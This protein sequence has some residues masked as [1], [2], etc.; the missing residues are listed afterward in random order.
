[1]KGYASQF[2]APTGAA[3]EEQI[4]EAAD[5]F[6]EKVFPNNTDRK[7]IEQRDLSRSKIVVGFR[8]GAKWMAAF[9]ASQQGE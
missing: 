3:S 7:F 9:K 6:G 1:M 8:E 5:K 2:T 4:N